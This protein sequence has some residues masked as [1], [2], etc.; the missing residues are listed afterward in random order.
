MKS[1]IVLALVDVPPLLIHF[2]MKFNVSTIKGGTA[3]SFWYI[4]IFGV[5][6]FLDNSLDFW[7]VDFIMTVFWTCGV[8]IDFLV[9]NILRG[10]IP[11]SFSRLNFRPVTS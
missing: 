3:S 8:C 1:R 6:I 7:Q 2:A 11:D 10:V 9:V 4:C 5:A